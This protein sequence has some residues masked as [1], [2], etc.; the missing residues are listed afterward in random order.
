MEGQTC[1]PMHLQPSEQLV[2]IATKFRPLSHKDLTSGTEWLGW[3]K[4]ESEGSGDIACNRTSVLQATNN[5][6]R[7][8][9]DY[10]FFYKYYLGFGSASKQKSLPENMERRD[11]K[12]DSL[13]ANCEPMFEKI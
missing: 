12:A 10:S 5:L 11:H 13:N 2:N 6:D 3:T 8:A 7:T 9:L 4:H 1:C